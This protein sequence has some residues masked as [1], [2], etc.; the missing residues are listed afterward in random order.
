MAGLQFLCG[1]IESFKQTW[2]AQ[3]FGTIEGWEMEARIDI[4]LSLYR[5]VCAMD[6]RW[7]N[8]VRS[9]VGSVGDEAGKSLRALYGCWMA[10]MEDVVGAVKKAGK[11]RIT[12]GSAAFQLIHHGRPIS[13]PFA[14]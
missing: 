8:A 13:F 9:R 4:G 7:S 6:E 12:F 11:T 10:A 2:N 1:Q 5:S 3:K 14:F